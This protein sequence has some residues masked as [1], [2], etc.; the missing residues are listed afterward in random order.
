MI[1]R[2]T[3][4]RT[5]RLIELVSPDRAAVRAPVAVL[6][7]KPGKEPRELKSN[8][9]FCV[10]GERTIEFVTTHTGR[11]VPA[12]IERVERLEST[13]AVELHVK[14]TG[15]APS[16]SP[17]RFHFA[18]LTDFA[19]VLL[20]ARVTVREPGR[21]WRPVVLTPGGIEDGHAVYAAPSRGCP[22]RSLLTAM[23][24]TPLALTF[25]DFN[26]ADPG[27][28][29]LEFRL[30]FSDRQAAMQVD[31]RQ[32]RLN[33]IP[34]INRRSMP[35]H[36]TVEPTSTYEIIAVPDGQ[37]VA[38]IERV[39]AFEGDGRW[40]E[41]LPWLGQR[42]VWKHRTLA[43]AQYVVNRESAAQGQFVEI[44]LA[45]PGRGPDTQGIHLNVSLHLADPAAE[46]IAVGTAAI[47]DRGEQATT[48]TWV[49]PLL[50]PR[51]S[52]PAELDAECLANGW[53]QHSR[54][55]D[56]TSG[57]RALLAQAALGYTSIE[58]RAPRSPLCSV[59]ES[60]QRSRS[61][62]EPGIETHPTLRVEVDLDLQVI[63]RSQECLFIAV[64]DRAV[65]L[66][67]PPSTATQLHLTRAEGGR[68]CPRR[69]P[70]A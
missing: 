65:S 41:C 58:G 32:I 49:A 20:D 61:R 34:V 54:G 43:S 31:P 56:L 48:V 57:L 2:A 66:C 19:R 17:L 35:V 13:G 67:A 50:I 70:V 11:I 1:A 59:I 3:V 18:N 26:F 10:Q 42:H 27:T 38:E 23:F 33:C 64:L 63:D 40:T 8:Y 25:I 6:S 7:V 22:G 30:Q 52:D 46:R 68:T 14:R 55:G 44:G 51:P 47:G 29:E 69:L 16:L 36:V 12:A 39:Q 24:H 5:R 4:D 9:M 15:P 60:L 53:L 28:P 62:V 37:I 21:E 45:E